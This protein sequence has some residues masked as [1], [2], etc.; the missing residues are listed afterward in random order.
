MRWLYIGGAKSKRLTTIFLWSAVLFSWVTNSFAKEQIH[1]LIRTYT[2]AD[3][4]GDAS[5]SV[6]RQG[7][8]G[9][10]YFG[11]D[12]LLCFDGGKW[13]RFPIN[14]AYGLRSLD[15]GKN[16]NLWAA[17]Y[18][19]L[20]WYDQNSTGAWSYHSLLP[21]LPPEQI[22]RI[23]SWYV[24]TEGDGALFVTAENILRWDGTKF[25]IWSMPTPKRHL[26]A[27]RAGA[28]IYI[29]HA[30]TGLYV[31][32]STGPRLIIP[33]SVL[34]EAMVMWLEPNERGYLLATSSGLFNYVD[35]QLIPFATDAS[36]YVK[37]NRLTCVTKL[38]DGRLALGTYF[39]GIAIVDH[40]GNLDQ[41]LTE[42]NGL[43]ANSTLSLAVDREQG[44]WATSDFCIFRIALKSASRIFSA[45]AE[46]PNQPII[47]ITRSEGRIITATSNGIWEMDSSA[48]KFHLLDASVNNI[49]DLQPTEHGLL[50]A[51]GPGVKK[52]FQG[53]AISLL[54]SVRFAYVVKP[55]QVYPGQYL[56]ADEHSVWLMNED[57]KLR[58]LVKD[59]P[60]I[61]NSI[62]EDKQGRLWLGTNSRAM[63]VATAD[64][65]GPVEAI[66]APAS[67]GLPKTDSGF[68][69]VVAGLNRTVV[70]L[71]PSGGWILNA[72]AT[73]FHAIENYPS[74]ALSTFSE[75]TAD[76][77]FWV[78]YAGNAAQPASI[79]RIAIN[80]DHAVWQPHSVDGLWNIGIPESIFAET[81]AGGA[82]TLW[83]GGTNGL[84]RNTVINGPVAPIP[85]PPL[86]RAFARIGDDEAAQSIPDSLPYSTRGIVFKFSAPEFANRS[87]LRLETMLD[88]VD[89]HWVPAD[90][91]S[92]REFTALRDGDYT[93][94]VRTVA[95]TGAVSDAAVSHFRILPPWWRTVPA[96]F[97]LLLALVPTGYGIYRWRVRLL[98]QR[99]VE[100][101]HKVLERTEQLEK[102][103]AAK[104][105]FV[106]NMSHDIRNPL[107][108]IVGLA[109]A[110]EDTWLDGKQRELVS[111][112][113]ECTSYLSTLVDDVLDFATIEAGQIELRPGP[114]APAELLRSIAVMFKM[115]AIASGAVL[116]VETD[117][118]LPPAYV[119]DAGRIQQILVNFVTNALKYAG[120]PVKLS[121]SIP[122]DAPEE[123]EFSVTDQGP[124]IS[125]EGQRRLFSKFSRLTDSQPR[126]ITGT[127]LGLASCRLLA[128]LMCGSVGVISS[129]GQGARFYLRLPLDI[130]PIP[131]PDAPVQ[132]MATPLLPN[133]TVLLVEDTN[134]NAMAAAAVL[135]KFGL[136]CDRVNNG[137]EALKLFAEKRHN[138]VLLDRNL[139]DMD[140]TEVARRIRALEANGP[141]AIILAVTAYCTL[142]D[143]ALCLNAGM[144]AFVGKPLTP[145]KLRR[146]LTAAG[147]RHLAAASMHVSPEIASTGVD[148]SL[149]EYISD[150]T[151]QG[152]SRQIELFLAALGDAEKQLD[153][154]SR[155]GDFKQLGEAAHGVL[156]HAR[157]VG[158][159]P[160]ATAAS[161]LQN[162]A[163]NG[164]REAFGSM[165][166]RVRREIETLTAEVRRHPG[167]ARPA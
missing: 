70:A 77:N 130:F 151:G 156:S 46:L 58:A 108:G 69:R 164:N 143:R 154:A 102:A 64:P 147:R 145:Q 148:V 36:A 37:R 40:E 24:F 25:Q 110:L 126:E 117:P 54:P 76:G 155:T 17:A 138:L 129:P 149:L 136:S 33:Q 120:G 82:T 13:D 90:H 14:G 85:A 97:G 26:E 60:D 52:L 59:L 43:P 98:R 42:K 139:P 127:G 31:M 119:G 28:N 34:G 135:S 8:D 125:E 21:Q 123:I 160:L 47:K 65:N 23:E 86:L 83:I 57:G 48:E 56:V 133:C 150:G 75:I 27:I 95:E 121:V 114:F 62:A 116:Q 15:F 72:A 11:S 131:E 20:G 165:L 32:Q 53:K 109:L 124:G 128:G 141:R 66:Q 113:R 80:G 142:E 89:Q 35:S 6:A 122:A 163:S 30:L 92:Q 140:G 39:G 2:S 29:H 94:R 158:S 112:L 41:I 153:Q 45:T 71:S 118:L 161:A 162:A 115:E 111:T 5:V 106:A 105:Q 107:N 157:L 63:F 55:S 68:M 166:S 7:P 101:E 73:G 49:S 22:K 19:E 152:L 67:F 50:V 88:G 100:L 78:A 9:K 81:E 99:N 137:A 93:F 132:P 79:A 4:G 3:F 134:Y 104:T 91:S 18:G 12:A 38:P 144:D 74:R 44:L 103:S 84:L 61:V 10:F 159:A 1:P 167:A 16:G 96:I 51:A 146:V 87:Q